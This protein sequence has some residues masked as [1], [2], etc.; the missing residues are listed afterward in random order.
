MKYET[1]YITRSPKP[2]LTTYNLYGQQ[3][4]AANSAKY[5]RATVSPAPRW[6]ND[7]HNVHKQAHPWGSYITQHERIL[8]H[9]G[10]NDVADL[11]RSRRARE[12]LSLNGAGVDRLEAC[13][14]Q[15]LSTEPLMVKYKGDCWATEEALW[16]DLL[17][18]DCC[19]GF[20]GLACWVWPLY[21]GNM[22]LFFFGGYWG[23]DTEVPW[24]LFPV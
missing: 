8:V 18:T 5:L 13:F 11:L 7:A 3:I 6:N 9:V 10:T 22:V 16:A 15:A 4:E 24:Y 2:L 23:Q 12:R 20:V 17:R 1:L 14:Q 21:R 19:D